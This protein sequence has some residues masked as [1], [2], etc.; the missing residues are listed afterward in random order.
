MAENKFKKS[1]LADGVSEAAYSVLVENEIDSADA[2]KR[3]AN[4]H[5]DF[6]A[7]L[8]AMGIKANSAAILAEK[9]GVKSPLP[10]APNPTK[11]ELVNPDDKCPH[12]DARLNDQEKAANRCGS[13]GKELYQ[14]AVCPYCGYEQPLKGNAPRCLK[15]LRLIPLDA[16]KRKR[17]FHLWKKGNPADTVDAL[18]TVIESDTIRL[19]A[20]DKEIE[21]G[22]Q[23]AT[24]GGFRR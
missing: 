3:L 22:G 6:Y 19:E 16:L 12:C 18:L 10:T 8:T 24:S 14:K 7:R 4:L 13:C 1:L 20:M 5:G 17:L 9:Y 11:I 2:L 21:S 23:A 15:C